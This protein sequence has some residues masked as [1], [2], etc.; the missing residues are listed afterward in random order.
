MSRINSSIE[1]FKNIVA[2]GYENDLTDEDVEFL[3][4]TIDEVGNQI[5]RIKK[6]RNNE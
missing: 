2:E 3:E 4:K 1:A 6:L 5:I